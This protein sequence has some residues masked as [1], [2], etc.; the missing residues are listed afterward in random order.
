MRVSSLRMR[1]EDMMEDINLQS[2]IDTEVNN[3][4][5]VHPTS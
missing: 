5:S 1:G 2:F 3:C 4:F